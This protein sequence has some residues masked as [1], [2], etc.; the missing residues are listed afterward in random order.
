MRPK[1]DMLWKGML[2][3]VMKDLLLFVEPEIG[4]ELDLQ[5]FEFLDKELAEMYP[6]P[7][8]PANTR[9]VDKLVKVFPRD[10]TERWLLLHLEVQGQNNKNFS[11]RIFEYFIKLFGKHGRPVAAIAIMTGKAGSKIPG[12]YEDRCLWTRA[13]YEYKTLCINDYPDE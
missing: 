1:Y 5:R 6:E 10:G 8:K 12:V 13:R 2:E 7:Q 3:E 11:R 9:V 4:K